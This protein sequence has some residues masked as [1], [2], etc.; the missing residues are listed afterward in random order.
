MYIMIYYFI[1]GLILH[2][3]IFQHGIVNVYDSKCSS[4]LLNHAGWIMIIN[5][6]NNSKIYNNI[7]YHVW[8]SHLATYSVY[9][10]NPYSN[11]SFSFKQRLFIKVNPSIRKNLLWE[12]SL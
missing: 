1:I 3:R 10:V 8:I 6:S 2:I 12:N 5:I 11:R 7:L 9:R 4:T